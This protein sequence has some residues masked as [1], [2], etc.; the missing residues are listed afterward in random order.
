MSTRTVQ[1]HYDQHLGP[2]Y[3][4]MMGGMDA[5]IERGQREVSAT[6]DTWQTHRPALP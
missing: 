3:T 5:A 6:P 1:E 2:I 4:W